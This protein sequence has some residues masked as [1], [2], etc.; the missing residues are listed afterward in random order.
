M[1]EP[2]SITVHPAPLKGEYLTVSD[3]MKQVLDLIEAVE[4]VETADGGDRTLVWRL[5][6]A[7]TNS[8]P[9]TV[10]AEAFPIHP[11][12]SVGLE[13]KRVS[14]IFIEGMTDLLSGRTPDW[15]EPEL[16]KPLKRA[17]ERNLNGIARTQLDY[18][19]D[20]HLNVE[21]ASA[22]AG[23]AA[24]EKLEIDVEASKV[25]WS[26]TEYGSVESEVFGVTRWNGR[27]AL[28]MIERLSE[29]KF[30]CVLEDNLAARVGPDHQWREA[31]EGRRM[32]VSGKLHYNSAGVL[33]RADAFDLEE[34]PYT[35][36]E[37]RDLRGIDIVS[38]RTVNE[39]ISKM[40]GGDHDE[41]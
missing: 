22:K 6:K 40:R 26:R 11:S 34:R 19:D 37:L 33:K 30:T 36:V 27:P 29:E 16:G 17:F 35:D 2:F 24:L 18:G 12:L 23:L 10:V 31:W 15:L 25:D 14:Q 32:L 7:H 20:V 9:F 1:S 4:M 41:T 39:H 3:A 13:A 8:P 5:T 38:D 28:M 21:P